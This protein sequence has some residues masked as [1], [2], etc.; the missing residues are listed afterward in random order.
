M[1]MPNEDTPLS[2]LFSADSD[3][4]RGLTKLADVMILNFLFIVTSLPVVT[5]GA[6]LTALNFTAM[7]IGTG[8]CV[9]VSA[10]YFRSFRRNFRQASVIA[11]VLAVLSG[12]LAAWYVVL[13]TYTLLPLAE[14]IGF[15]L[16]YL[17]VFNF[18]I[19][20]L[21]VFP[22]LATFEGRTRDVFRNARLIAVALTLTSLICLATIALSA[23]ATLFYP[24]I[25]G[26]GLFW[27]LVG[28]AGI[29]VVNGLMF[30]RVFGTYI[31]ASQ[32]K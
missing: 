25:V 20:T 29:A 24:Q 10:D 15:A 11:L 17:L 9:S 18:A 12:V 31:A 4:M 14:L 19:M 32:Q 22:Y 7:R 13:S 3:L 23:T 26:F 2:T 30:T 28:F 16:W 1:E 6:S 5:L 21:F 8:E 27:L